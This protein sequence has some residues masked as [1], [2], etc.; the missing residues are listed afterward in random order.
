MAIQEAFSGTEAVSTTEWSLTTDAA[1]PA[2]DTTDGLMQLVLDVSDM[3]DGDI[4]QI[5]AYEKCRSGDTQRIVWEDTLADVQPRPII[6]APPLIL[7]HG[8]DFTLD[9]L[10]GTITCLWSIRSLAQTVTQRASGTHAIDTTEWS[11]GSDTS[12]DTGDAQTTDGHYQVFIDVSD[13]TDGDV[14][15][16]RE[17]EKCRSGDTQRAAYQSILSGIQQYPIYVSPTLCGMHGWD[18]TLD[19]LT[20]TI[21]CLWSIRTVG[22]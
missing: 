6:Y 18:W 5:R 2:A 7:M 9:A 10:A 4:L 1:G 16:I 3:I 21:T 11:L 8:W 17:Y 22:T 19:A 13:M 14:L 15:Q 12:Y 20:G